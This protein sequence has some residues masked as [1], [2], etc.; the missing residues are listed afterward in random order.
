MDKSKTIRHHSNSPDKS[1]SSFATSVKI[2]LEEYFLSASSGFSVD[3]YADGTEFQQ[4]VWGV[5]SSI[6]VGDTL[7]YS[8]VA[9]QLNSSPRAVGNACRANPVPIIVPCHRIVSKSGIGGFAGQR[10]GDNIDVKYWLLEHE[11]LAVKHR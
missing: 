9:K 4:S 3:I 10:E 7:T 11:K 6:K 1:M 2:Q 5:I 8:D